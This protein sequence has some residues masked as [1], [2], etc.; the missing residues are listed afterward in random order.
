MICAIIKAKTV[1]LAQVCLAMPPTRK[2][3]SCYRRLQRFLH[4]FEFDQSVIF[5]IVNALLPMPKK[6][7][8]IMDRTNWKFGKTHINFL[9]VSIAY[10]GISI[11]ITWI[12]LGKAGNSNHEDRGD[13]IGKTFDIVGRRRIKYLLADREF[14]GTKW[15]DWLMA[16]EI[17]FVIRIKKNTLIKT[18]EQA[19][20][21]PVESPFRR[22]KPCRTKIIKKPIW[23]GNHELFLSASRSP[24]GELLIIATPKFLKHGLKIYRKR[25]EIET[26]FGCLKSKGF[27]LEETKITNPKRLER[28]FFVLAIAFCWSYAAGCQRSSEIKIREMKNGSPEYTLFRFGYDWL[29]RILLNAQSEMD[30]I[31]WALKLFFEPKSWEVCL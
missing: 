4:E 12:N 30:H 22:L 17:R 11:P 13:I 27:C 3:S 19:H 2:I 5:Q 1:N 20:P 10:Q 6:L 8:L 24:E 28:L 9:V 18:C 16:N 31:S 25:W 15:F 7:I 14:V 26:L 23:L 29:R 21:I